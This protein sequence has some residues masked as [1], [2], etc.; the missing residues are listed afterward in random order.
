MHPGETN[1]S[2]VLH[3]MIEFLVSREAQKIRDNLIFKI[4]PMINPDGVVAGN[5]R[6]SFIGKDL[7]RLFLPDDPTNP[8]YSKIDDLLKPET[9]AI[10]T[11][12]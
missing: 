1:S 10:Q 7:N 9:L 8:T 2:W 3:G 6:T 11:L 12:I 5:Y 4:V